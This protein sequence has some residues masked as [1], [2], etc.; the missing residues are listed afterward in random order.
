MLDQM[1]AYEEKKQLIYL[2]KA[3]EKND[4]QKIVL[5]DVVQIGSKVIIGGGIGLLAGIAAITVTASAAEVVI[6]GVVTKIAGAV[7]SAVGLSL[8][9]KQMRKRKDEL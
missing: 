8:G 9:V 1:E 3:Q 5:H 4:K 7:G 2:K 6:A